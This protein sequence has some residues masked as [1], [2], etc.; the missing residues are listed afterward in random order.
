MPLWFSIIETGGPNW[1]MSFDGERR[2][3]KRKKI[4]QKKPFSLNR[5]GGLC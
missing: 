3:K 4:H 5:I 2:K 1:A